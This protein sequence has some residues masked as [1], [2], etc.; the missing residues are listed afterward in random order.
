[1]RTK[2]SDLTICIALYS[3]CKR[4]F[5]YADISVSLKRSPIEN[6]S[7]NAPTDFLL[8][9]EAEESLSIKVTDKNYLNNFH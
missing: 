6:H 9:D 4:R 8:L 1:M 3:D 5:D 2:E 7:F